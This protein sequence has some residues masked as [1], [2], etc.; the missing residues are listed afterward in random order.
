MYGVLGAVIWFL[1]REWRHRLVLS[2]SISRSDGLEKDKS[3]IGGFG[4]C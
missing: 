4:A 2:M 1:E 3:S